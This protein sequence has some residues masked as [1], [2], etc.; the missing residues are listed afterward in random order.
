MCDFSVNLLIL[1][2]CFGLAICVLICVVVWFTCLTC[3]A[4][5]GLFATMGDGLVGGFWC[6]VWLFGSARV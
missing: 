4:F 6:C 3:V 2:L 5:A 1:W